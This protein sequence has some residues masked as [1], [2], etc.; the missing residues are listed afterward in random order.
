MKPT[1][2]VFGIP[3]R[4]KGQ[5]KILLH[6][7]GSAG[8][9]GSQ[10]FYSEN[11]ESGKVSGYPLED[12]EVGAQFTVS[13]KSY[14]I[15]D[16][17]HTM[18]YIGGDI[19]YVPLFI[20]ENNTSKDLVSQDW[21]LEAWNKWNPRETYMEGI[22]A[23]NRAL[24][25]KEIVKVPLHESYYY[26]SRIDYTEKFHKLWI[27]L[28]AY[29]NCWSCEKNDGLMILSLV[30]SPLRNAFNGVLS[31]LKDDLAADRYCGL[32]AATGVDMSSDIVR[33][34]IGRSCSVLDFLHNAKSTPDVYTLDA[35]ELDGLVFLSTRG[36]DNIFLKTLARYHEFMASP[37]GMVGQFNLADAFTTP[38]APSSVQRVGRLLFHHPFKNNSDGDLFSIEDFFGSD[39][40]QVPYGGQTTRD[41][42]P[43]LCKQKYEKVDPLFFRY[44]KLLYKFRCDYFH[45]S[46]QIT[47]KNNELARTAY[48]SL[49]E[50][51]AAIFSQT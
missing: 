11:D 14:G 16:D 35:K 48:I 45:G 27:G 28:N 47:E 1:I 33:D 22:A 30:K 42:K 46:V 9:L 36:A 32:Q 29:A 5:F 10:V 43:N 25:A 19:S 4:S 24:I 40:A 7:G 39:Y 38:F 6:S 50:I 2:A 49:R 17:Y 34:E 13:I 37:A 31:S 18:T 23:E 51:C 21:D 20:K 15:V 44:L 41:D 8:Y 12:I 3:E 26:E